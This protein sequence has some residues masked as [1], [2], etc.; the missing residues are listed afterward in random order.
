MEDQFDDVEL[1]NFEEKKCRPN[2]TAT[3]QVGGLIAAIG[4]IGVACTCTGW[5]LVVSIV[6]ALGGA[7]ST[8]AGCIQD[9]RSVKKCICPV[10]NEDN[11][12]ERIENEEE[13]AK[14]KLGPCFKEARRLKN[15]MNLEDKDIQKLKLICSSVRNLY[16]ESQ[17]AIEIKKMLVE[18]FKNNMGLLDNPSLRLALPEYVQLEINEHKKYSSRIASAT[19]TNELPANLIQEYSSTYDAVL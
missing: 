17:I 11:L 6:T 12:Y 15:A 10:S 18:I 4:G 3:L 13:E 8:T 16:P 7:I 9:K 14:R 1:E 5:P 19:Q 2:L